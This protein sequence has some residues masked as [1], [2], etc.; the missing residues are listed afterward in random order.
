MVDGRAASFDERAFAVES[1]GKP[2]F[3]CEWTGCMPDGWHIEASQVAPAH[4]GAGGGV[5]LVVVDAYGKRIS[6]DELP[7]EGVL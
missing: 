6:I 3:K 4:G 1:L 5:Q 7:I 2:Y